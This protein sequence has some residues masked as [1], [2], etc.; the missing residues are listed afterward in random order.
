MGCG[1]TDCFGGHFFNYLH[2]IRARGYRRYSLSGIL[3][4][5]GRSVDVFLGF[6]ARYDHFAGAKYQPGDQGVL[7]T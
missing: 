1:P 6:A 5:R 7:S 2:E 4:Y 3:V